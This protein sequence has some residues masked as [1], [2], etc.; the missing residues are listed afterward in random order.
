MTFTCFVFLELASA[1]QNRGLGCGLF[2]NRMLITTVSVSF[3]VQLALIY[4]PSMQTVFQ[5]EALPSHDLMTLLLL[6][7]ASMG[8]HEVRRRYERAKSAGGH[9]MVDDLA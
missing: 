4:V 5:T 2:Q 9:S 3:I 6:G 1:L 8:L 7:A